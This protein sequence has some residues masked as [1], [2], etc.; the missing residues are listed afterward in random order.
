MKSSGIGCF[1]HQSEFTSIRMLIINK[2]SKCLHLQYH[3]GLWSVPLKKSTQKKGKPFLVMCCIVLNVYWLADHV[4]TVKTHCQPHGDLI[5][6]L[7]IN[8]RTYLHLWALLPAPHWGIVL[9]R[10]IY[11]WFFLKKVSC[12]NV[13]INLQFSQRVLSSQLRADSGKSLILTK[14]VWI[15]QKLKIS[16]L[17]KQKFP[18]QSGKSLHH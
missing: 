3:I 5:F 15:K 14:N 2:K 12:Q 13:Q 18:I 9:I 7:V 11:L 6:L 17:A 8:E 1:S 10:K 4:G 16:R